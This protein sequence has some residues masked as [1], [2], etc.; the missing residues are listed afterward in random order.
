MRE[1]MSNSD[2]V[3]EVEAALQRLDAPA[4]AFVRCSDDVAAEI[5]QNALANFVLGNPRV[6]WLSLK[7]PRLTVYFPDG[8]GFEHLLE[9]VPPAQK[10][11][12]FIPETGKASLPVFD[13]EV[14]Y[15][16]RVLRKCPFFEYYLVGHGFDWLIVE[17]DHNE[18]IVSHPQIQTAGKGFT[19]TDI[20]A[21]DESEEQRPK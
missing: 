21:S 3:A 16:P 20:A 14:E 19:R 12:W 7:H 6:W 8:R 2:I 5:I 1:L 18:V 13:A 15:I 17:N 11:C 10:R 9:Y 4:S